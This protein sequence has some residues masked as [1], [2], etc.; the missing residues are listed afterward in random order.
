MT[1]AS[2]LCALPRPVRIGLTVAGLLA[3]HAVLWWGSPWRVAEVEV[4]GVAALV[5][6]LL[7]GYIFGE[8]YLPAA[9]QGAA[10]RLLSLG[11]GLLAGAGIVYLFQ[12][13]SPPSARAWLLLVLDILSAA[14]WVWRRKAPHAASG[15]GAPLVLLLSLA[16]AIF[17]RCAYLGSAEFQGDEARALQLALRTASGD[18]AALFTHKKGPIEVLFPAAV[19]MLAGQVNEWSARLPFALCGLLILPAVYVLGGVLFGER[20][21]WIGALAAILLASEGFLI[22]FSRI[23]QYQTP[24]VFFS[25]C[26]AILLWR[27]SRSAE[28]ASRALLWAA[29]FFAGALLAHYDAVLLLPAFAVPVIMGWYA[30]PQRLHYVRAVVIAAAVFLLAA[31]AFYL[32]FF[33]HEQ[34]GA[35]AQYLAARIGPRGFPYN[36]LGQYLSLLSFYNS[37]YFVAACAL[38]LGAG[39]AWVLC[40][41]FACALCGPAAALSAS[42]LLLC[43]AIRPE[44][45]LLRSGGS[46]AVAVYGIIAL[47]LLLPGVLTPPNKGLVLSLAAPLI[48]FACFSYRPNTHYYI[49]HAFAALVCA[50]LTMGAA[51]KIAENRWYR[52]VPLWLLG[53]VVLLNL[54]YSYLLFVR[55]E[56]EYRF[57][58]PKARSHW[59]WA[60]YGDRLPKGAY[61]GFPHRSGWK[62]AAGLYAQGLLRGS[63]AS[64][65]EELITSWYLRGQKRDDSSPDIY[66]IVARPNDQVR[67]SPSR[68]KAEYTFWGRVL[69][70]GQR[71]MD[72]F[73]K[74]PPLGAPQP[75]HLSDFID[76][77]DRELLVD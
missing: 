28:C 16:A 62:A 55:R 33:M 25:L 50:N 6:L 72:I 41:R 70:D 54:P 20:G 74:K 24:L 77:F 60:P 48:A 44:A 30:A 42:A 35:T 40:S 1:L 34:F 67:V 52:R 4:R 59:Y 37:S 63:Y 75:Y 71:R 14:G 15:Q 23:V 73:S 5:V 68:I 49:L 76:G 19:L 9:L 26:A 21:R 3:A 47:M 51:E 22:A 32:P 61:F 13:L 2:H 57:V 36:N 53:G 31:A 56:P 66:F 58:Y 7:P 46:F 65:E 10:R 8:A 11:S 12:L 43:A 38:T 29:L 27:Q 64:N 18:G 45:L 17:L 39:I 69:V